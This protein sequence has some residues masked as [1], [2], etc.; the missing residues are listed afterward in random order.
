MF[1]TECSCATATIAMIAIDSRTN[2]GRRTTLRV[3]VMNI[4]ERNRLLVFGKERDEYL[5]E[6]P[7]EL[8]GQNRLRKRV[9]WQVFSILSG[10]LL[11]G[12]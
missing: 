11:R 4:E 5:T 1:E 6:I 3:K 12:T 7:A 9:A 8:N 10:H 2:N